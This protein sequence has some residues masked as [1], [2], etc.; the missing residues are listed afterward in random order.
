MVY[1]S[2]GEDDVI[3]FFDFSVHA[4]N[5]VVV[6]IVTYELFLDSIGTF[7]VVFMIK[8]LYFTGIVLQLSGIIDVDD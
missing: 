7:S 8:D 2:A 3:G 6:V 1:L 4:E 5:Y